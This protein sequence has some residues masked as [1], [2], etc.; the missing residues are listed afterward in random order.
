MACTTG[1]DADEALA[2]LSHKRDLCGESFVGIS[3]MILMNV[4][5]AGHTW[6]CR[7]CYSGDC[8]DNPEDKRAWRK[9]DGDM[10]DT[11]LLGTSGGG[12]RVTTRTARASR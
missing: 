1:F 8:K 2:P 12:T 6:W 9:K 11:E 4:A 3:C 5:A 7:Q 10:E